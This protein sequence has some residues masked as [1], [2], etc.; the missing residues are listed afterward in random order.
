MRDLEAKDPGSPPAAEPVL[1]WAAMYAKC[2]Q[3]LCRAEARAGTAEA[4]IAELEAEWKAIA[5]LGQT[6]VSSDA[7]TV[8]ERFGQCV[9]RDATMPQRVEA[10][11]ALLLLDDPQ[12]LV[13]ALFGAGL[14]VVTDADKAVL[15]AMAACEHDRLLVWSEATTVFHGLRD[16]AK[17][18][19][20]RREA[21]TR[22]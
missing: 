1:D 18:E 22:G 15:D 7:V 20:A 21:T 17:A 16:A 8:K 2:E 6:L 3:D 10:A 13:G 14:E 4:R 12:H 19:L 5:T 9:P 11:S